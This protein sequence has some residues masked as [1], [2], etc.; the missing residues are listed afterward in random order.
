MRQL[1]DYVILPSNMIRHYVDLKAITSTQSIS[2]SMAIEDNV[3]KVNGKH[4][5][6]GVNDFSM[7]K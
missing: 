7:I 4:E 5:L 2:F 3:F 1:I 6:T